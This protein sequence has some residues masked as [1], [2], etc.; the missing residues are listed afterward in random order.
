MARSEIDTRSDEVYDALP[1][2]FTN[3][4]GHWNVSLYG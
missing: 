1:T 3:L 4:G 2:S